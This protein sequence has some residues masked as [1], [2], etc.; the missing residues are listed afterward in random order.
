MEEADV[1]ASQ[2]ESCPVPW[3]TRDTWLGVVVFVA[4]LAGI[5]GVTAL[6]RF[7]EWQVNAGLSVLVGE[8]LFL[9]PVWWFAIRKYR[10]GWQSLGLRTFQGTALG[11]GCGLM[12]LSS[13]FNLAYGMFLAFFGL[14]T[15]VDLVPIFARLSYPG[16][17]M[18]AGAVAAPFVEEVFFRGF[19]FAGLRPRYGW[20][21]SAV[22]S[23]ALFALIH[24]QPT[25]LIPIFILGMI[26]AFL[27]ERS[28]S[29]W[30]AI[31]MHAATNA[32]GLGVAYLA[33][34]MD[35]PM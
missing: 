10:V 3:T 6:I 5:A 14:R 31:V 7:L 27:Y 8:L 11:L 35:L 12:I 2:P 16:L 33:S 34:R 1:A 19:V 25:A 32:L 4:W 24:L 23:S 20:V 13:L 26:F 9:V 21:K 29:I 30:P 15:Q 28:R 22:I 17:L 18:L